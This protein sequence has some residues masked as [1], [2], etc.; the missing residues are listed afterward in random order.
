MALGIPTLKH[1][2]V[3]SIPLFHL[4]GSECHVKI[5]ETQWYI[6]IE[7]AGTVDVCECIIGE[8]G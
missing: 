6:N 8:S 1:L 5:L 2:R 7:I 4:N 3:A